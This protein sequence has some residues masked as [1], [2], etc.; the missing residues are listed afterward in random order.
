MKG[1]ASGCPAG[2][3]AG[4]SD[5]ALF[6]DSGCNLGKA[7]S[8]VHSVIVAGDVAAAPSDPTDAASSPVAFVFFESAAISA[9]G[10]IGAGSA[11]LTR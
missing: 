3:A 10:S 11:D 1:S 7:G 2:W 9:A 5:G 6:P 8:L 4:I